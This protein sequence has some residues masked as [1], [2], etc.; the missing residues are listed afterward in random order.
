MSLETLLS[1]HGF[2][3]HPFEHWIAEAEDKL[4]EWFVAP[5]FLN[6][7]LGYDLQSNKPPKPRSH[8]VFGKLGAGKTAICMEVEREL[9]KKASNSLI[10]PYKNFL[11]PLL[12]SKSP[13]PGI[14]FHVEEILRLGTI[15]LIEF[16]TNSPNRYARLGRHE[17][18][19]LAGLIDHYYEKLPPDLKQKY[20]NRL[21]AVRGTIAAAK[22]GQRTLVDIYNTTISVIKQE[23]IVPVNWNEEN[24][25]IAK[26]NPYLRLERFWY[27]AKALGVESIWVLIDNVDLDAGSRGDQIFDCIADLLLSQRIMEFRD[28]NNQQVICFHVFLSRHEYVL[29]LLEKEFFRRDRIETHVI[30]WERRDLDFAFTKRLAFHSN[31]RVLS[32]DQLCDEN[33]QGTHDKLLDESQLRPRVLFHMANEILA[34]FDRKTGKEVTLI[35]KNSVEIGCAEGLKSM[36]G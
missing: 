20:T 8:V 6:R 22:K 32:F 30:K 18:Q 26:V 33:A 1:H 3:R 10:L 36:L 7:L 17:K 12:L 11:E 31:K 23:K 29:D 25:D 16:W 4:E 34:E 27:L 14:S 21:G 19:Q 15:K 24:F 13:R 9:L 5:P 35:D 2:L 28:E